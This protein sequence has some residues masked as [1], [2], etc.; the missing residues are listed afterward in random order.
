MEAAHD[1]LGEQHLASRGL[2]P[3]GALLLELGDLG[4]A[5]QLSRS[6]Q[7]HISESEMDIT[8]PNMS[9]GASVMPM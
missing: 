7:S 6:Y 9:F 8:L 3:F 4:V 2:R 5:A 1:L